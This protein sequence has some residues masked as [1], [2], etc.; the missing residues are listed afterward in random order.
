MG[1]DVSEQILEALRDFFL[2]RDATGMQAAYRSLA[3]QESGAPAAGDWSV[4]EFA[5]NRLFVG[6]QAVPAP[7]YASVYLDEQPHLMGPTS[8]KSAGCA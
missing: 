2:A 4:L 1:A 7:P 8:L 6:P 5:F 3:L